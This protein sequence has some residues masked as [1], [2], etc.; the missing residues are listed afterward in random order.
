MRLVNLVD[1]SIIKYLLVNN[2]RHK[3]LYS[4]PVAQWIEQSR[5]KGKI[6]VRFLSGAPTI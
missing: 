1:K 6:E 5:P 3:E 2:K 4:A